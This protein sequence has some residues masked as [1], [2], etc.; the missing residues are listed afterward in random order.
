MIEFA[1][2]FGTGFL[3]ATLL[4]MLIAPAIQRRI[5]VYAENRLKATLPL[6]PQEVRAQRD[7]ARAA[8]AAEQ[9]KT[10]QELMEERDRRVTLQ[11]EQELLTREATRLHS[12]NAELK[13]QINDMDVEAADLRS[14]LRQGETAL[15]QLME[16]FG[17]L[18]V[19][20]SERDMQID[21]LRKQVARASADRDNLKIDLAARNAQLESDRYRLHTLREERDALRR[22]V[23]LQ[24]TRA[25]EAEQRLDQ[26][27]HKALRL[28]DRLA[29][30]QAGAADKDNL[31]ERR[32]Q[33]INR[34]R[35][36]IKT[37]SA[38][39]REAKRQLRAAANDRK[40]GR[41]SPQADAL[42]PSAGDRAAPASAEP[43]LTTADLPDLRDELRHQSSALAEGL[44][45]SRSPVRDAALREELADVAA[46][47]V[48]LTALEDGDASPLHGL[49]HRPAAPEQG[50]HP[51]LADRIRNLLPDEQ[52]TA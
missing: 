10:R 33:E 24:S 12:E 18:E 8:F 13:M 7:M 46:R 39:G 47:M 52:P 20:M 32:Q 9:S 19:Q 21:G 49:I 22:D 35:E 26:E 5:V 29:R 3:A 41:V 48:A 45:K 30:E 4:A 31:I 27:E 15:V 14:S 25:R 51:S 37:I 23:K 16:R 50:P 42:L 17:T 2:L 38:E 1:L 40:A 6:S 28:A 34:L 11:A 36:K 43:G 44:M